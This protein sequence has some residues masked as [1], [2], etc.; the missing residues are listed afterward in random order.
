VPYRFVQCYTGTIGTR[1]LAMAIEHPE[2]EV[3]GCLVS[4]DTKHGKDVGELTGGPLPESR[5]PNT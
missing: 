3:V 1:V 2:F 5:P 4:G